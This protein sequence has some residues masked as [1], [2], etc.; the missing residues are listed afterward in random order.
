MIVSKAELLGGGYGTYIANTRGR[1]P[2]SLGKTFDAKTCGFRV[3]TALFPGVDAACA[4]RQPLIGIQTPGHHVK[5]P[6]LDRTEYFVSI[7]C[8][9]DASIRASR[10]LH[11][12]VGGEIGGGRNGAGHWGAI[13]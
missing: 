6:L 11:R 8:R 10:L 12:C 1:P 3:R 13:Y 5:D 4:Q 2:S 9:A 7:C